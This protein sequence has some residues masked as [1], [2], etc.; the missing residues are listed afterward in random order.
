MNTKLTLRLDEDLIEFAK[1]YAAETGKPLSQLVA[2]LFRLLREGQQM[3]EQS[4]P[5]RVRSLK[6]ALKGSSLDE[7]D[8]HRH[9]EQKYL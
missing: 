4:L 1:A 7:T 9:L 5:P 6:G 8:Y 3:D 2:D